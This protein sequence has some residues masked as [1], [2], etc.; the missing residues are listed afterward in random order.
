MFDTARVVTDLVSERLTKVQ[1][2]L[3]WESLEFRR[4]TIQDPGPLQVFWLVE[5]EIWVYDN[6]RITT[7]LLP[8]ESLQEFS[9]SQVKTKQKTNRKEVKTMIE[10]ARV[11][12]LEK[13]ESALKAFVDIKV[14]DAVLIKGIRVMAKKDGGLFAAMPSHLA[15]DGKYYDT[16]AF[17]TKEAKEELQNVVLAAYQS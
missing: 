4:D 8:N 17:L 7:M 2:A 16:V 14:A 12:K 10:V 3:V 9:V 6:G 1:I 5:G 11:Y 15:G 13:D